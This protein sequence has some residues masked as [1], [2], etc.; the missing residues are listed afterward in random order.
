MKCANMM[1]LNLS[2]EAL[3]GTHG[4]YTLEFYLANMKEPLYKLV[5]RSW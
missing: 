1:N 3:T 2:L 4:T 5:Y